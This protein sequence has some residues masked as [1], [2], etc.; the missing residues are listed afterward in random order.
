MKRSQINKAIKEGIKALNSISFSLPDFAFWSVDEWKKNKDAA[1][2]IIQ[3]GMGWD[4][5][6]F[7]SGDFEKSA[8]RFSLSETVM[9]MINQ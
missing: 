4:V 6:D 1:G 9:Y 5:T 2:E 7:G 3:T 8:L